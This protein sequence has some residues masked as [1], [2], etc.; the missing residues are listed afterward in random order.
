MSAGRYIKKTKDCPFH[1]N[2]FSSRHLFSVFLWVKQSWTC[3]WF[4]YLVLLLLAHRLEMNLTLEMTSQCEEPIGPVTGLILAVRLLK[5]WESTTEDLRLHKR[6]TL[7][8]NE[9]TNNTHLTNKS[10]QMFLSFCINKNQVKP[11][12][13]IPQ[14]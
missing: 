4:L 1:H 13:Y 6:R 7:T 3:V 5:Y 12:K 2:P 10:A 9:I 14:N 11:K 8:V